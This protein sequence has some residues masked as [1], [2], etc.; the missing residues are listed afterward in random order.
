MT[1]T[2][3][4]A[5]AR[6][7][8]VLAAAGVPEPARDARRLMAAVLGIDP[9]R[10][11]LAA[12]DP[13]GTETATALDRMVDERRRFRPVAQIVGRRLFWGREFDVTAAVLDPRPETETLIAAALAGPFYADPDSNAER[14]AHKYANQGRPEA[15]RL[16]RSMAAQ[17]QA[18]W[19][20]NGT[21]K[22]VRRQVDQTV[23]AA[24]K[25]NAVAVLVAYNVPNRDCG[26]Y[27]AGGAKHYGAGSTAS[28]T[29]ARS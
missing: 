8:A 17:P 10:V 27:S 9:G 13:V 19:Y 11:T 21:P 14:Q 28:T 18:F 16:M 24:A 2:V 12:G 26:G 5:L 20:T 25:A 15:A 23:D 6:A 4:S 7:T 22:Q 1:E 3:R 29:A